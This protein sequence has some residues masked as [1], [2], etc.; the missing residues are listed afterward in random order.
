M[1]CEIHEFIAA[2]LVEGAVAIV[3]AE[4]DICLAE[5]IFHNEKTWFFEHHYCCKIGTCIA[6]SSYESC[7]YMLAWYS[8]NFP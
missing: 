8:I 7:E 2:D 6:E 5:T 3:I 4:D 1:M